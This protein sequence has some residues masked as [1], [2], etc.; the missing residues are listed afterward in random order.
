MDLER[1]A[2]VRALF[3]AAL[4]LDAG[5]RE[6]LLARD[7][8]GDPA[9]RDE[10]MGLLD[11]DDRRA[12]ATP[13]LDG[14]LFER[15][16]LVGA[17]IGSFAILRRIGSGGMGTV[18][19][20]RQER[21]Q[22]LVAL[23]TLA[24]VE[25]GPF[26][27]SERLRR[28]F[29]DE[30]EILARLRHPGIAQ[31]LD[32]GTLRAGD[33]ELPW[34]AMELVE[35]AKPLDR[36]VREA[37]L[38]VRAAARLMGSVC[39]AVH[40]AHQRGVLHRDLKPGNVLVDRSGAP[41]IID[42]GIARLVDR[43]ELVQRTQPG[44]L[45]GTLAYMSP[46]RLGEG[47][48]PGDA[49]DTRSDVYALGVMLYE[50]GCGR[51]PYPIDGLPPTQALRVLREHEPV[52]P[53]RVAR[54]VIPR[55]LDWITGKAMARDPAQRYASAAA[56]AEDLAAFLAGEVV[57]AGPPSTSYRLRLLARRHRA[58]LAAAAIAVLALAVGVVVAAIGWAEARTAQR[59]AEREAQTADAINRFQQRILGGAYG[60]ARGRDVRLADLIDAAVT[61]LDRR[62][63][64]EPTVEVGLRSSIGNSYLGLGL[65][66]PAEL[67]F[68]RA[69]AL[70]DERGLPRDG[71]LALSV[72][73]NLG[74]C[75]DEL[76]RLEEAEHE[77]R[78]S[79]AGR[80]VQYGPDHTETSTAQIN[81]ASVLQRRGHF[82]EAL[83]LARAGLAGFVRALGEGSREAISA[84]AA[85]A[86]TLASRGD[87]D[88]AD[89]EYGR[90]YTLAV[91][92]L[93]PTH[94]AR[95]AT[96]NAYAGQHR[97]R[98]R[99]EEFVRLTTEVVT[100]REQVLGPSHPDTLVALNNLAVGQID[101]KAHAAAEA[102][103]QTII[104]RREAAGMRGGF[105]VL[106]TRQNLVAVVRR[107]G[108]IAEAEEL[109][110]AL[111]ADAAR[112]LPQGHWLVGVTRKEHGA[113]LRELGRLDEAEAEL[114]GAHE[115]LLAAVGPADFRTQKVVEELVLLY[116]A[117]SQATEAA[118]WRAKQTAARRG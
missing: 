50:L 115:H 11:A 118:A 21:P 42:F 18:Y 88:E 51:S 73:N 85:V 35:E 31:I 105:E 34:F 10:V 38:D 56:L 59:D 4:D 27:A 83:A 89:V 9:L 13:V 94:P 33:A 70:V 2:R 22:R 72:R 25:F 63:F 41:K 43:S 100:L 58:A 1:F 46:E 77:L 26:A 12:R 78:G 98:G 28:R 113:C 74:R 36:H 55:E 110:R 52:P 84:R 91:A 48:V 76:G 23:K 32:A 69:L 5:A 53:S 68:R 49:E 71:K 81:L 97:R 47:E 96:T 7:C 44:E 95:L 117:R 67:Q 102:T 80:L 60:T 92:H 104:A 116:E 93:E 109:A 107:Q 14:E 103:L 19:E 24:R 112:E 87:L 57:R 39:E 37:G 62:P 101:A 40:Y 106:G 114:L 61:D 86:L 79:L 75:L 20:A 15:P 45:L 66:I 6:A 16:N 90:A 111:M 65:P 99:S 17:R 29:E 30:A 3:D 64:D 108:R 54:G 82:D 8:A